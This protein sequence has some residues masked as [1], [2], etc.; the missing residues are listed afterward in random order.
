M[1][2]FWIFV[3]LCFLAIA[4]F[5]LLTFAAVVRSD[6]FWLQA[7]TLACLIVGTGVGCWSSFIYRYPYGEQREAI[8]F[9]LPVMIFEWEDGH[10][11][12][13]VGNP[14]IA[15][16]GVFLVVSAFLFPIGVGVLIAKLVRRRS[17]TSGGLQTSG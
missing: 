15:L 3:V 16:A 8:G 14:L 9:P 1:L 13:Y 7:L 6:S 10:W 17:V 5:D 12:D 4:T 2:W 11:V